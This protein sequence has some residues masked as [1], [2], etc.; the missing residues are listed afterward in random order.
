MSIRRN[1]TTIILVALL[2]VTQVD[3]AVA[4]YHPISTSG[5]KVNIRVVAAPSLEDK[6]WPI[7]RIETVRYKNPA[8]GIIE[9][10]ITTVREAPPGFGSVPKYLPCPL[11]AQSDVAPLV[12]NC[13][14]YQGAVSVSSQGIAGGVTL[15]V[16]HYGNKFC[17]DSV[18]SPTLY[19]PYRLE[20]W[21]TRTSSSW[22]V[23]N[24]IT[25]WGCI[26]C[27]RCDITNFA[28]VWHS[29]SFTP[30]WS[31]NTSSTY[32]YTTGGGTVW[33]ALQWYDSAARVVGG[34]RGYAVQSGT[35]YYLAAQ[36]NF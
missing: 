35:Q 28:Y 15:N 3:L 5:I 29:S 33:P 31:G 30:I 11:V 22:T 17:P 26:A 14:S 6:D 16:K 1:T 32:V 8:T 20:V 4:E 36:A 21:W 18:C 24:A 25:D 10:L 9:V 13:S 19:Q 23:Q 34:N 12:N 2:L 7:T 27:L